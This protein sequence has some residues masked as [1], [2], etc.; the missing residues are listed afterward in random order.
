MNRMVFKKISCM[1]C[2]VGIAI[3]SS[4]KSYAAAD[5]DLNNQKRQLEYNQKSI[6]SA[7]KDGVEVR[8]KDIA[9][10]R[11]VRSNFLKGYGLVIGLE[12]TGD[13]KGVQATS[14]MFSNSLKA[15]GTNVQP[16]Q[17]SSKNIALVSVTAELPPFASPGSPIDVT[18]QSMGDAK[19]LQGGYLSEVR[20]YA[21]GNPHQPMAIAQGALSIGGFIARGGGAGG[22]KNHATIGRVPGGGVI[23]KTI[24]T[25]YIFEGNRMFLDLLDGDL[26]TAQRVAEKIKHV[27]PKFQ[28]KAQDGGTIQLNLPAE[29]DYVKVMSQ[30]EQITV[31]ADI[32]AKVIVN[33]RTGTIVMGGNVRLGPAMVAHGNLSVQI[34]ND[35]KISGKE[36]KKK[37]PE[38]GEEELSEDIE[39]EQTTTVKVDEEKAQI[40]LMPPTTTVA[41]LAKIFQT[42]KVSSRDIIAILQG[43]K[44]QGALKARLIVQ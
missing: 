26:T 11:G 34:Q 13:S 42:L 44:Q 1:M 28:V 43:L 38:K 2:A 20:L 19:S 33:E 18:V 37:N 40:A 6:Q 22:Q 14:N 32:E 16:S 8:I 30:V 9:K 25:Q 3:V 39:I 4:P 23:E 27:F 29:A 41:D 24:P 35:L 7:E 17:L 10:F 31:L 5:P 36:E 15:F 21:V 12:G